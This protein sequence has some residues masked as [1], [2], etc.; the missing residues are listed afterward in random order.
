MICVPIK[1]K[2]FEDALKL[3]KKAQRTDLIE[4]WGNPNLTF[5][6]VGKLFKASKVPIIYKS[7]GEIREISL[8]LKHKP[9]FIDIDI[10]K[11]NLIKK[12]R[13]LSPKTKII[14]SYHNFE[15]T[16][17]NKDLE[18]KAKKMFD[19]GADIAKIAVFAKKPEDSI[20]VLSLLEKFNMKNKKVIF[21]CMGEHG[22]ITRMAGHLFGNYLTYAPLDAKDKTAD[23]QITLKE[24]KCLLK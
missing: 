11:L 3:L 23:G 10:K 4:I 22:K 18:A 6:Q 21:L 17:P 2:K 24:L 7:S 15:K 13:Q 8:F 16:P 5:A 19:F 20:R 1:K 12:I 14:I 9:E